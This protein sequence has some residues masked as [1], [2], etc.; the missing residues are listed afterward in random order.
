MWFLSFPSWH[1]RVGIRLQPSGGFSVLS[2]SSPC[3]QLS[4]NSETDVIQ[5]EKETLRLEPAETA[6][7]DQ[8]ACKLMDGFEK[9]ALLDLVGHTYPNMI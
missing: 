7:R 4:V 2:H 1:K 8:F 9:D 3:A 5:T 6:T